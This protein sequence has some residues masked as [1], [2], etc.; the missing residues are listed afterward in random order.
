MATKIMEKGCSSSAI[1]RVI[2][3][4]QSINSSSPRVGDLRWAAGDIWLEANSR[5]GGSNS[6]WVV[7]ISR[8]I[9][10]A[11]FRFRNFFFLRSTPF[12]PDGGHHGNFTTDSNFVRSVHSY[13]LVVMLTF[14]LSAI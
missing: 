8:S 6:T 9:Q 10:S 1:N 7:L 14:G 11:I 13:G 12:R 3:F 4:D 2:L 5:S